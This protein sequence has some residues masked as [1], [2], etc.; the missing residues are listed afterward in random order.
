MIA[1]AFCALVSGSA[2]ADLEREQMALF[3]QT[4]K[5]VVFILSGEKARVAT[6]DNK[7]GRAIGSGFFVNKE[8][9][10]TNQ[11]VVGKNKKVTVVLYD[12]QSFTGEV[13]ESARDKVDIRA[14]ANRLL[15]AR[16]RW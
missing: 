7:D 3:D 11:H 14:R 12:G 10:V 16:S 1:L 2:L 8:Y 9:N 5:S 13:V 4:A 15:I 6:S